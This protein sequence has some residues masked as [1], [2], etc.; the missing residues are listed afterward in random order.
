MS[1]AE[2][3]SKTCSS[4]KNFDSAQNAQKNSQ[5]EYPIISPPKEQPVSLDEISERC[6]KIK[7]KRF[8]DENEIEK[9]E[10]EIRG[11]SENPK[12]FECRFGRITALKCHRVACPHKS[13]TSPSKIIKEVLNYNPC[14]Q[15]KA[16]MDGI[17]CEKLAIT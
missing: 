7:H 9:I 17:K 4:G 12:W 8:V 10:K 11:H 15:T 3:C 13:S 16:M 5:G 1:L 14:V 2:T 6:K